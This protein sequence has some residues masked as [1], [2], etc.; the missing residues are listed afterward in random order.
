[1][2]WKKPEQNNV[3]P[4][5]DDTKS[6]EIKYY[7]ATGMFPIMHT[8]VVKKDIVDQYPWVSRCIVEAYAHSKRMWY[9]WRNKFTGGTLPICKYELIEQNNLLGA[10]P[11]PFHLKENLRVIETSA[12]YSAADQFIKPIDDVGSLWIQDVDTPT[13]TTS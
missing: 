2:C 9:Q 8:V 13:T 7:K 4:L 10:D 6:E 1:M 12:R 3:V 5:F 11:F